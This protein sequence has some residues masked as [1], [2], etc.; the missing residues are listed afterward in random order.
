MPFSNPEWV[1]SFLLYLTNSDSVF[2]FIFFLRNNNH[3]IVRSIHLLLSL[4]H[5]YSFVK[6]IVADVSK[7][8]KKN[9]K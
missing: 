1:P 7:F 6:C 8:A 9:Q 3:N 5:P 4:S 2:F